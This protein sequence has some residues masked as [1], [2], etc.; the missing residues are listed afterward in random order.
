MAIDGTYKVSGAA[1]G[2]SLEGTIEA[3]TDGDKL[4]GTAH[5]MDADLPLQ[6]GKVDGDNFT[7]TVEAPT[8]MGNLKFKVAGTVKGDTVEGTLKHLL[9]K[10]NFSGT[11]I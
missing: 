1:K 6:D 11:R 7:C 10:A 8:P 3:H 5:L 9:V 4:T 2:V